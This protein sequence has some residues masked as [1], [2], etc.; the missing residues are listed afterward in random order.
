MAPCLLVGRETNVRTG[1]EPPLVSLLEFFPSPQKVLY[2]PN[3]PPPPKTPNK[4]TSTNTHGLRSL[5]SSA[6]SL[7]MLMMF[8]RV[9]TIEMKTI[10]QGWGPPRKLWFELGTHFTGSVTKELIASHYAT[11]FWLELSLGSLSLSTIEKFVH[12]IEKFDNWCDFS[13]DYFF[14]ARASQCSW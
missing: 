11:P 4:D 13:G 12:F 6:L 14:P 1:S 8:F 3:S 5:F 7:S 9:L 10:K 2:P